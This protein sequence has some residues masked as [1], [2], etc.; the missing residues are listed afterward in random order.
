MTGSTRRSSSSALTA[1]LRF[2]TELFFASTDCAAPAST[3][4][5]GRVDSPPM[6]TMSAP[7]SRN[8]PPSENESG[9]TLTMPMISVRLPSS[10]ARSPRFHW[11]TGLMGHDFKSKRKYAG[12]TQRANALSAPDRSLTLAHPVNCPGA[13]AGRRLAHPVEQLFE[14]HRVIV[15]LVLG[16]KQQGQAFSLVGE[17]VEPKQRVLG[18]RLRQFLQILP[19]EVRPLK[20]L[21]MLGL[22]M[23][24]LGVSEPSM[25]QPSMIPA[26]QFV[27]GRQ[28]AQPLVNRSTIFGK[29]A[30]PQP[31]N[32]HSRAVAARCRLVD[33]LDRHCHA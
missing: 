6:S 17:M 16:S 29:A 20:V 25:T 7:S 15:R 26:A 18:F 32:Q 21:P 23:I 13:C 1:A 28:V 11:K 33:S 3:R 27:R 30:R 4:A 24:E 31:V 12:G 14:H 22:G 2:P 8:C 10:S 5:P 9:V 19:A